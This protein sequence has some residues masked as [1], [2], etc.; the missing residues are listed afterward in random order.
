[1][2]DAP[3]A[4]ATADAVETF[5]ARWQHTTGTEKANYQLFLSELCALLELPSPD[6]ASKDNSENAYTF[7]RRVDIEPS[8]DS[9][10]E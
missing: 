9:F 1:M 6:P 10:K 3:A 7:E 8:D 5:I 4:V 2:F